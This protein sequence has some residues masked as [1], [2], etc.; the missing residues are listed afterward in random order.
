M[1][2]LV[3]F[4]VI[5]AMKSGTSSLRGALGQHDDIG[6]AGKELHF[7]SKAGNFDL[8]VSWYHS[9]FEDMQDKRVWGEKSPSYAPSTLAPERIKSYNPDARILF[10]MRQPA[11]LAASQYQHSQ[12]RQKGGAV[13]IADDVNDT[14]R[15]SSSYI[16]R[17]QYDR[18]IDYWRSFFPAE[19]MMLLI[20]EEVMAAPDLWLDHIQ[21]FIGVQRQTLT[22][23]HNNPTKPKIKKQYEVSSED[24]ASLHR[25]LT[26][27]I[28]AV[29][30]RLGRALP[31]W[32][33]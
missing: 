6:M 15:P 5:G 4:F 26:P 31:L 11:R 2:N 1:S 23:G 10:I 7:F 13:P 22:W 12:R 32:R 18:Q 9:H 20:F 33:L 16:Y 24:M 8:G 27:T 19:Q 21:D 28:D 14:N 17:S 30:Q 3:D 25:V 29:E